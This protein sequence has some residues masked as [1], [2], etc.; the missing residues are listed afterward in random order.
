MTQTYERF[1]SEA[2][3]R[4][5]IDT[6]LS[7]ATR[8]LLIFDADLARMQLEDPARIALLRNFLAIAPTPRVRLVLRDTGE[9]TNRSPRLLDLADRYAHAFSIRRAPD[10]MQHLADCHVIADKL[11]CVRRFHIDHARGALNTDDPAEVLPWL[12]R[13]DELW[14]LSEPWFGG[15]KL[16]V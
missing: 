11:H 5:A 2:G 10:N 3:Y 12:R 8:E 14:E 7:H 16:A 4:A 15:R 9:I 6:V 13:F 1:D